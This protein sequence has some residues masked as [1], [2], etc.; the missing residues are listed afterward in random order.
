MRGKCVGTCQMP[1]LRVVHGPSQIDLVSARAHQ[2]WKGSEMKVIKGRP[3]ENSFGHATL[4][5]SVW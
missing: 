1:Q 5:D 3:E 4:N 2:E